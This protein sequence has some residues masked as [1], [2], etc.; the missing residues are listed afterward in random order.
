MP[1]HDS[2]PSEPEPPVSGAGQ[3]AP[4]DRFHSIPLSPTGL[5]FLHQSL[6]RQQHRRQAYQA[7]PLR[8]SWDGAA[9][10]QVHPSEPFR[11]PLSAS[12]LE[13]FGDDADGALLLAVFPLPEPEVLE[14]EGAQ[15]L[16]VK[17]EGGQ[18][19]VLEMTLGEGSGGEVRAYV[20]QLAYA[21]ST[22]GGTPWPEPSAVATLLTGPHDPGEA[23]QLQQ[24]HLITEI[25]RI[26]AEAK[27]LWATLTPQL[28]QLRQLRQEQRGLVRK[29]RALAR[30]P[31][32]TPPRDVP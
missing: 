17:L 5:A 20:I 28:Q 29:L 9:P 8:V 24:A 14:D 15:H 23:W 7:G 31:P 2:V 21:K 32:E 25:R 16:S 10:A 12:Y 1:L 11:V 6:A 27:D 30:Q 13:I 26:R 22:A 19:V 18:T 4:R 3:P